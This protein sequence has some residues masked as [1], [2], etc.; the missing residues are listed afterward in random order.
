[1]EVFKDVG[2]PGSVC[3]RYQI[4]A[5]GG[6]QGLGHTRMATESAVTTA[7][8]HPLA[9]GPDLCLA[10]NGSF[11]NYATVRRQLSDAGMAFDTDNDWNLARFLSQR[12]AEGDDL[13]GPRCRA[14]CRLSTVSSPC[15]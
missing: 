11:S 14:L 5:R 4:A 6:Y 15:W 2:H 10:H 12:I 8:S 3:S 1:M 7:H 9:A 13:V